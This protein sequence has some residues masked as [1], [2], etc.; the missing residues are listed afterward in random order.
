MVELILFPVLCAHASIP[1]VAIVDL[2]PTSGMIQTT[3]LSLDIF[4]ISTLT[5][6]AGRDEASVQFSQ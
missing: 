3:T 1:T 5:Y 6:E 4:E 2:H